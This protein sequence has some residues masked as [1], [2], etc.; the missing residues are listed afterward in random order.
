MAL[1]FVYHCLL[2]DSFLAIW[3][4]VCLKE[5][6]HVL[7]LKIYTCFEYSLSTVLRIVLDLNNSIIATHFTC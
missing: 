2:L 7:I 6:N 4:A 3:H 5:T 1:K